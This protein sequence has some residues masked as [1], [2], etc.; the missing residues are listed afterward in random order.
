MIS[1][2][3]DMT[4][5][6]GCTACYHRCP[7][8]CIDMV[9]DKEGFLS[10]QIDQEK[11]TDCGTCRL[12]C[13]VLNN[14][15]KPLQT[16]AY[17]AWSIDDELRM[18]S[19]SGGLF[20][21]IAE[22]V[23]TKGGHVFGAA[24]RDDFSVGHCSCHDFDNLDSLRRSKYVQSDMAHAYKEAET[25]LKN[26]VP[27]LFT[28]TPCQI[29]GLKCFLRKEYENLTTVDIACH[30]VPSPKVWSMYLEYMQE[31]NKSG[32]K[33]LSFRN[34]KNGWTHATMSIDFE[35]GNNYSET[36]LRDPYYNGFGKSLFTRK[37]C[38]HCQFRHMNTA[39]DITLADFWGIEKFQEG[40]E[41]LGKAISDN[42]GIS[43]VLVNTLKG[44][45]VLESISGK[46]ILKERDY[47]ESISGN[48]RLISSNA[49][50]KARAHFFR[51]LE[52]GHSFEK[53]SGRY[54]TATGLK[55][56]IKTLLKSILSPKM[57]NRLNKMRIL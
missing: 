57:V 29:A 37:S 33:A 42:K 36:L 10:S 11:C 48:P 7:S 21:I 31:K 52:Q 22:E 16:K 1:V 43:L 4:Q 12:V 45:K 32:I 17:A 8:G 56:K 54:M 50:P 27:V 35:S 55:Q 15:T 51:D 2:L 24:F 30:G 3:E 20:S 40:D 34:K 25:L 23:I 6:V 18:E 13:P 44:S 49:I 53:L 19:S 28:G 39:A 5:C 46:V 26:N 41:S 47:E 14:N 9:E 38:F